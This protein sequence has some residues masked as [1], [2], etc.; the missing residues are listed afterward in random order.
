[1]LLS[2]AKKILKKNGFILEYKEMD[3]PAHDNGIARTIAFDDEK[4]SNEIGPTVQIGKQTWMSKNLAIDDGGE[5]IIFNEENGEYYYTWEAAV[6]IAK[7][8]SGWHLP[9]SKEWNA[10]AL[11]FGAEEKDT[12][13][14]PGD[15]NRFDYKNVENLKRKLNIEFSGYWNNGD[16]YLIHNLAYFWTASDNSS[17]EAFGRYFTTGAWFCAIQVK[18]STHAFTVRLVKD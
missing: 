2:E 10:A 18:K 11:A 7:N 6:R 16:F 1:M 3:E 15:P 12:S 8:I 9:T 17:S 14:Y 4:P 5:G 13:Y